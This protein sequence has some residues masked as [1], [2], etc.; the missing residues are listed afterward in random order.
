MWLKTIQLKN[1]KS[2]ADTGELNL[3]KTI[4]V[5]VG[6]N[7]SGKSTILRSTYT[8]QGQENQGEE[9]RRF[10]V[11]GVRAGS[12]EGSVR[13]VFSEPEKRYFPQLPVDFDMQSWIPEFVLSGGR[14]RFVASMRKNNPSTE[15]G[16]CA[17]PVFAQRE[18]DNFIYPYF[19][20]R[21]PPGFDLVVNGQNEKIV[22]ETFAHLPCK[23][24]RLSNPYHH[25]HKA[26]AEICWSSLGLRISTAAYQNGKHAGLTLEDGT[27]LPVDW[28]GEGTLGVLA[29]LSH[30]CIA[31][32]KLFLIEEP[33][34]DVHPSALKTLL[35]FIVT[36]SQ[37]NQFVVSTHS[38]IVLKVL[39]GAPNA[40]V[41]ALNMKLPE[42]NYIPTSTC[43]EIQ[44]SPEARLRVLEHMGYEPS[45]LY[46]YD[47]YLLLEESTAE[48]LIRDFMVPYIFPRLQG[49]LRTI[50]AGGVSEV[51]P[52]F[53]DFY[54]LFVYLHTTA[55]YMN[56]GWVAVDAGAEGEAVIS[57][58]RDK[59]K[60]WSP[61]Q[62]RCFE[63]KEFEA[64]YPEKFKAQATEILSLPKGLERQL[65]KGKLA[66]EVTGWCVA[67]PNE[68]KNW[69][70]KSA[71][72]VVGLLTEIEGSLATRSQ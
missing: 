42:P 17:Q 69:F 4:N 50:S 53:Q 59:F 36:K 20:R 11:E 40:K 9:G 16:S 67:H 15:L 22:E 43:A 51:E 14:N 71:T 8:L 1:I 34:N 37:D 33:E 21:K 65:H 55:Q 3:S 58:L 29:M 25:G 60:S 6:P 46:L 26:F 70:T 49:K 62:F 23:I 48:R 63:A 18:P 31:K 56:R 45:D 13:L 2:F 52:R 57:R 35:E 30:L 72:D 68:A 27:F 28:M 12:D 24:D 32:G 44:P 66:E 7:N 19:S 5:F 41:F 54:R 47:A 38:N 64:Y 61:T 10:V 39:G